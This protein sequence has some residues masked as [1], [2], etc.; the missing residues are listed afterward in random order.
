MQI[1]L[2]DFVDELEDM[3]QR[4]SLSL[5]NSGQSRILGIMKAG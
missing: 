5:T 4:G 3:D 2:Y 1:L